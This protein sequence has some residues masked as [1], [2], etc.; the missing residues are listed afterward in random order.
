LSDSMCWC[1]K[2]SECVWEY[3]VCHYQQSWC[4]TVSSHT[5]E[6]YHN[7]TSILW[8]HQAWISWATLTHKY[9]ST[10]TCFINLS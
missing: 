1:A 8:N 7:Q 4:K 3:L 10:W 9:T 6:S 5:T 2:P